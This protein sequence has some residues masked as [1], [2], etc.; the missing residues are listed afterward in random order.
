MLAKTI[1]NMEAA[2]QQARDGEEKATALLEEARAAIKQERVKIKESEDAIGKERV[3]ID[4]QRSEA[5]V[6]VLAHKKDKESAQ[7]ELSEA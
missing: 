6:Q 4:R 2:V 3:E 5:N 1:V 7:Y